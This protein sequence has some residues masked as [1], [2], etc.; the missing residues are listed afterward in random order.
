MDC[1]TGKQAQA[2]RSRWPWVVALVV[3]VGVVGALLA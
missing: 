3:A 2:R 1:C